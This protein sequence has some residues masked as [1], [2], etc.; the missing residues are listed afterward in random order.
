MI[1]RNFG[2]WIVIAETLSRKT[3]NSIEKCFVCRCSCGTERIVTGRSLRRGKSNSC[4]CLRN[5]RIKQYATNNI[6]HGYSI[7]GRISRIYRIWLNIN[8]RCN[9]PHSPA[10]KNYGFRGIKVCIY[11]RTF[12]NFLADMGDPPTQKHSIDRIDNNKGYYKNNCRWA[13][14]KEQANNTK[15]NHIVEYKGQSKT[16]SQWADFFKINYKLLYDRI[17][18]LHWPFEKAIIQKQTF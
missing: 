11:W 2:R 5:E 10:Y 3:G 8:T 16:L 7:T 6:K 4:G 1:N 14:P 12:K 15:S 17:T 18:K 9:N 13:T